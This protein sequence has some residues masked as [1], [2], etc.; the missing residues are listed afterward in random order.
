MRRRLPTPEVK[1]PQGRQFVP[2]VPDS[3][4]NVGIAPSIAVDGQGLPSISYFGFPAKL[5]EGDIPVARPVGS[6]FLRPRTGPT[7]GPCC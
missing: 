6:P 3:I 1:G 5:A 2:M 4:D 7:P